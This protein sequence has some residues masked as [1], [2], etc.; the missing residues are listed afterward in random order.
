MP[1]YFDI[2][3]KEELNLNVNTVLYLV[4]V[5]ADSF[6]IRGVACG[7]E[8]LFWDPLT[9]QTEYWSIQ[10]DEIITQ[11]KNEHFKDAMFPNN[12]LRTLPFSLNEVVTILKFNPNEIE[13]KQFTLD[14]EQKL[15]KEWVIQQRE[16]FEKNKNRFF[17]YRAP[18]E[19]NLNL[20]NETLFATS[21]YKYI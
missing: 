15:V 19:L 21:R 2:L 5:S 4:R 10:T 17:H 12:K 7:I 1:I 20:P 6:C 11:I 16:D 14:I 9:H 18:K 13:A 3:K 8:N